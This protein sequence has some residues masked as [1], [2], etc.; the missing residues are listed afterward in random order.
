MYHKFKVRK[1]PNSP[2]DSNL[3]RSIMQN[4]SCGCVARFSQ[5]VLLTVERDDSQGGDILQNHPTT[6]I[7]FL[8][9]MFWWYVICEQSHLGMCQ[10]PASS[11]VLFHGKPCKVS[12]L[13]TNRSVYRIDLSNQAVIRRIDES[14][15]VPWLRFWFKSSCRITWR[16]VWVSLVKAVASAGYMLLRGVP[17][18]GWLIL[19]A[20]F[21]LQPITLYVGSGSCW[22]WHTKIIQN[23][24]WFHSM[25]L[26]RLVA[27]QTY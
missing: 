22:S 12:R 26:S 27:F 13:T 20:M 19:V 25:M 17:L 9:S 16:Q 21:G 8:E 18:V 24:F 2:T 3:F 14:Y 1:H 6:E 23:L 11:S 4:S 7:F 5:T 10:W 15:F